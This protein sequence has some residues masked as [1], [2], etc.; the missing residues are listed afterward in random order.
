[1]WCQ[2]HL[3]PNLVVH[4]GEP[5]D[6]TDPDP[7]PGPDVVRCGAVFDDGPSIADEIADCLACDGSVT[8]VVETPDGPVVTDTRRAP[9]ASQRKS[10]A[11]RSRTCQF[12]G[13]DHA[14][15]FDAHHVVELHDGG[16]TILA[17]LARLCWFHHRAVHLHRLVVTMGSDHRLDVCFPD[18][19]PVDHTIADTEF[20]IAPPKR[21]DLIGGRWYGDRLD[22]DYMLY[23]WN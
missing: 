19:K 18:G 14:G 8:T 15:R 13:C 9:T 4:R 17:N 7:D 11:L 5:V 1:M 3:R 16:R 22:L 12:P 6:A 20:L 10:L 23:N 21:P 2:W